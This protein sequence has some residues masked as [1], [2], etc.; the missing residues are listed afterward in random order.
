MKILFQELC[1][2]KVDW[3]GEVQGDLLKYWTLLLEEL[4]CLSSVRIPRCYFQSTPV[5]CELHGFCDAS[6]RA[7]AAVIYIRAIYSDG[8]IGVRL[9]ASKSRVAPLKKQS[10]PRLELLG[11]VLLARLASKFAATVSQLRTFNWTDSMTAL[12]WIKNE[13]VWKQYVQH[14]VEEIREL[15]TR[16]SWRHCPG[17]FNPADIPSHGLSA[18]ELAENKIWWNGAPFL[19][20]QE[21]EWPENKPTQLEDES[22]LQEAVKNNP[23][24]T[25]SLVNTVAVEPKMKIY[26]VID[27]NRISNL[28]KLLRVTALVLQFV[29]K[30]KNKVRGKKRTEN[31]KSLG[32]SDLNEAE[33]LWIKVVQA[34]SFV[35]EGDFL[36]NRR[37]NSKP[38]AYVS[39]FELFLE[40]DIIKCKGRISNSPLPSNSRN[41]VLLPAKHSFVMLVIKDAHEA[42]KNSGIRDTLTT[43]RERFW[44][45]CGRQAV[46][47]F[48]RKCVICRRY[49]GL[50]YKSNPTVDLPS[51]RVSEDPPFTHVGLDFAGPLFVTDGISEGANESS[52]V[53]VCLYTWR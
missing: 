42:V 53:Y 7:Y 44:I 33:K 27:I 31:W 14:R 15:T 51:E 41:P 30:L 32:A 47:Q 10:I 34:S 39:Q 12:C 18:R 26:Q 8:R 37:I 4:R 3:D 38:P 52:K 22:V 6:H 48:I 5:K 40:D 29:R 50:S 13:K 24:V 20:K 11:A 9:V 35:E 28:T 36:K 16:D 46:K 17:E 45:L 21:T 49:E 23:S 25:Y 19:Y 1:L 2:E 43:L